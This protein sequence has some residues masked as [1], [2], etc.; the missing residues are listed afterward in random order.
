VVDA[1]LHVLESIEREITRR[2]AYFAYLGSG[3]YPVRLRIVGGDRAIGPGS[4]GAVRMWLPVPLPLVPGDRYVLREAGRQETVGGGEVL[5]VAPRLPAA[6]AR[7]SRSVE[8]VVDG[9]GWVEAD[10]LRRL[11]G[12]TVAPTLEHWVVS[13]AALE[14]A[15][16]DLLGRIGQAGRA[17]LDL[18]EIDD[19]QRTVA[20]HLDGTVVADGRIRL[21]PKVGDDE[22]DQFEKHPFLSA[23]QQSPFSPPTP[24]GVDRADLRALQRHGLVVERDGVWF[25]ASAVEDAARVIADLLPEHPAGLSVST[26]RVALGTSR[27]YVMPLL[28]HLDAT[29]V[30][31]RQGEVRTAGRRLPTMSPQEPE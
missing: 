5:D 16:S 19:R 21:A 11:T 6:R 14:Q 28:A 24:D 22:R 18:T 9:R 25:A 3:E 15:R 31:R 23:L 17:G 7:P 12:Q 8:A 10:E 20:R 13:P 30:T 2:G 4:Q 1:S 26:I 27:K 29:G